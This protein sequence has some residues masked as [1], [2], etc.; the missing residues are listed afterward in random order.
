M[1]YSETDFTVRTMKRKKEPEKSIYTDEYAVVLRLL[2]AAR[3]KSGVT[4][5]ELAERLGQTQSFVS[6]VERGDRRLDIVQLRT[7]LLEFG[8]TLPNFATQL[9][10][11]ITKKR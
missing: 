5:I 10:S 3:K 7:I 1:A 6:K 11:E 8:V 9:E 2:K 4:Q